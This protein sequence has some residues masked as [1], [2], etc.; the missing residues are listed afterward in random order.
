MTLNVPVKTFA[1]W[2]LGVANFLLGFRFKGLSYAGVARGKLELWQSS[3]HTASN[4][5]SWVRPNDG[6]LTA[7][8]VAAAGWGVV[9]ACLP[10]AGADGKD[11]QEL[12]TA[13]QVRQLTAQQADQ[14][15]PVRL[16]G[17]VTFFDA[18]LF[19]RFIQ[20]DTSGIYLRESN[21]KRALVPGEIVEVEGTTTRGEYA[22]SIK[23]SQIRVVGEGQ[24]PAANRKTFNQ[25]ASGR[26][27]SQ[28]VEVEGI[29][30]SIHFEAVSQHH[31]IEIATGGGRL[32]VYIKE[33]PGV[34]TDALVA[35]T[36]RVRG[37]CSTL[38]NRQRQ[39]FAI[40]L[41]VPRAEDFVVVQPSPADPFSIPAQ[42]L[43]SLLQFTPQGTYGQRVKISG[44][45]IY[46]QPGQAVY[47][48]DEKYGLYVQ[49]KQAT[50]LNLGDH[51]QVL[52]FPAQGQYTPVLQDAI[53]RKT[54]GGAAMLPDVVNSDEVLKG[55]HDCRLVRLEATL[56]DRAR[57]DREPFLV[58]ENEGFIFQ[59][60]N[61]QKTAADAFAGLANG[62]RVSVTGVCFIEPGDWRA[63]QDW[64]AKSFRILLRSADDVVELQAPPWWTPQKMLWIVAALAVVVLAASV[65]VA[66]L[67]RRVQKQ[68]GII[69]Q[70]LQ[71]EAGLKERY[72]DLFENAND[73]VFTHDLQGRITSIN[74]AGERLL[75]RRRGDILSQNLVA[76]VAEDQRAA[77]QQWLEQVVKGADLPAAEWDF[78]N[79]T[80]Q[81]V[82]LEISTRLIEQDGKQAEAEGI[83]RDIT[84]RRRLEREILEISNRE[85]RRIGHDLHDGVCQ[86]LAG[87][88]YLVDILGDK[89][90]EQGAPESVEA[91]KIV[92]LI[93]DANAQARNV[94]RGLFPV[95]LEENGLVS[96]LEELAHGASDRFKINCHFK[97][98]A[99]P[100]M[101]D[102]EVAL[103]LYFITQEAVLNAVKHG[104]ATEV[105]VSLTPG[106]SRF[107]LTIADN[108]AGFQLAG[109]NRTGMGI[110]IMRH[111]AR[112]IGA[113]LALKSAPGRGTQLTC[114]FN[115]SARETV[116]KT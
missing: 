6:R 57:Q 106:G 69:R 84:E 113:T 14:H 58:L 98:E 29:V 61:E 44:T 23:P 60:Y 89:L 28:F 66:V 79:D 27:D 105:E 103:H 78:V 100:V 41:M 15:L 7:M 67:R 25:L 36:V 56:L 37:V 92:A 70:Q 64:R 94:A 52:G 13:L 65:W 90:Q 1:P 71:V 81:R 32:T 47:V 107:V 72:L 88:A 43:G 48:A 62:S 96:A 93:N 59:A 10:A 51:V 116:K 54:G 21:I 45:V 33:L 108:G 86:Q 115:P 75:R 24:L 8:A 99:P 12:T 63:A 82:K 30:R 73:M 9:L 110:R 91:E 68:T 50:P 83:A 39:L 22:P 80:G 3:G 97:C 4:N 31:L 26:E 74:K 95:R 46:Q 34:K 111:R 87:I 49:T 76:L 112:V 18:K 16:R 53:Y 35:S 109:D 55:T 19:S 17:T 42:S 2:R 40:R 20:D 101:V 11:A 104:A 114:E 5:V 38:F 102:N 77:A 85:Q